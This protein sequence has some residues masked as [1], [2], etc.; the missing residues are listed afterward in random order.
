MGLIYGVKW[1]WC[2]HLWWNWVPYTTQMPMSASPPACLDE[3]N[4]RLYRPV[5]WQSL[6]IQFVGYER[7]GQLKW[8]TASGI[9]CVCFV[10]GVGR[11]IKRWLHSL[12]PDVGRMRRLRQLKVIMKWSTKIR[13]PNDRW[14]Q[15]QGYKWHLS[16]LYVCV[17]LFPPPT[18]TAIILL[19]NRASLRADNKGT[20][21][22]LRKTVLV[23]IYSEIPRSHVSLA[24]LAVVAVWIWQGW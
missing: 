15:M 19:M 23:L 20:A 3:V 5:D 6:M 12:I 4:T 21:S 18:V 10:G 22:F 11:R 13:L 16:L 14:M 17:E 8:L 2:F 9:L 1:Q 7:P 24:V